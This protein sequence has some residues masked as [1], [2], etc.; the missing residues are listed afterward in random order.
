MPFNIERTPVSLP[1]ADNGQLESDPSDPDLAEV[2]GD[3]TQ[4]VLEA[5]P[6]PHL[7]TFSNDSPIPSATLSLPTAHETFRIWFQSYHPWFPILHHGS[8]QGL[9]TF[10]SSDQELVYKA[11]TALIIFDQAESLPWHHERVAELRDQV[12]LQSFATSSLQSVQALLVLSNHFY[13]SGK[14]AEFW[15][16]LAICKRYTPTESRYGENLGHNAYL[17]TEYL[18]IPISNATE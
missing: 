6:Q 2:G 5:A 8:F 12:L 4:D 10:E 9:S 11:V 7:N 17:K 16:V 1:S 3:V 13:T 18:L 15:N 14:L